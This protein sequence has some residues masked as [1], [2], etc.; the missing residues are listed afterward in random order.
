M[1]QNMLV[2][3]LYSVGNQNFEM[4][5][6]ANWMDKQYPWTWN[7]LMMQNRHIFWS[8]VV[9]MFP[10]NQINNLVYVR[11]VVG[12]LLHQWL[13]C[14]W[15]LG[16]DQKISLLYFWMSRTWIIKFHLLNCLIRWNV[17]KVSKQPELILVTPQCKV[18]LYI[19]SL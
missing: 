19:F 10:S 12:I 6:T 3:I 16:H 8:D 13:S 5:S 18:I 1:Y 2:D 14:S 4:N 15:C 17:T 9:S 11:F 7:Q